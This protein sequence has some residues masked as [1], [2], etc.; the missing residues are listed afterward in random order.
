[1]SSLM[2]FD[3]PW[4]AHWYRQKVAEVYGSRAKDCIRLYYNDEPFRTEYA[5]VAGDR[6]RVVSSPG[7]AGDRRC[8]IFRIGWKKI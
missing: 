1:M 5:D 8:W 4:Q 2:D 6:L 3:F 7:D